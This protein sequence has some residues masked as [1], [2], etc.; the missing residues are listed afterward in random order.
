MLPEIFVSEPV[1]VALISAVIGPVC[2]AVVGVYTNKTMK[3]I[4]R[5]SDRDAKVGKLKAQRDRLI[6]Q[7]EDEVHDFSIYLGSAYSRGNDKQLVAERVAEIKQ[8][9]RETKAEAD[10][11]SEKI[12]RV[13]EEDECTNKKRR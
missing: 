7:Y 12:I 10:R 11:L 9:R 1:W 2:V 6:D 13:Y 4:Q 3:S 5:S 8:K